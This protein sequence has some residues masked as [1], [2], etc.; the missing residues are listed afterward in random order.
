MET[1]VTTQ[2]PATPDK[3]AAAPKTTAA[4]L[5]LVPPADV[6]EGEAGFLVLMDL[7]GVARDGVTLEVEKDVLTVSATRP[8][9]KLPAATFKRSFALPVEVDQEQIQAAHERGV[10]T[11][12]LPRRASARP[13]QIAIK[14]LVR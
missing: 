8:A 13:R 14:P 9:G 2:T 6:F 1:N 3:A 5:K 4:P 11:L 12:T 10:L 7:V